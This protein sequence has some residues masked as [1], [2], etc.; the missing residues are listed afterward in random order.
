MHRTRTI[1]PA[2]LLACLLGSGCDSDNG[3]SSSSTGDSGT[4]GGASTGSASTSGA[5]GGGTSN[6]GCQTTGDTAGQC[7]AYVDCVEANC[8][9]CLDPC[10]DFFS[11]SAACP[12]GDGDCALACYNNRSP[13]CITCLDEQSSC[14]QMKCL[15]ELSMC[16]AVPPDAPE[17]LR[18]LAGG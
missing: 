11:C 16:S 13:E 3:D 5:T 6:P 12:C 9:P 10:A 4:T 1:F 7:Q 18:A 8:D 17:R 15:D 14:I 2:A